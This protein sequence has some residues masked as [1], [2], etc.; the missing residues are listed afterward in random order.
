MKVHLKVLL[1]TIKVLFVVVV[2]ILLAVIFPKTLILTVFI[3]VIYFS[4]YL[5]V[6]NAPK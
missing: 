4:C 6:I 5:T 3:G 2:F 1:L